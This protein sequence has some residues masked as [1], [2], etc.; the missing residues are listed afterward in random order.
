MA[1][2]SRVTS[3]FAAAGRTLEEAFFSQQDKALVQKLSDLRKL[4]ESKEALA[5]VSG[6]REDAVLEKL[7]SLGIKP[8]IVAALTVVPLVE[9]AWADGRVDEKERDA[10]LYAASSHGIHGDSVQGALIE[11]WLEHKPEPALLEAWR[12]Y[13]QGLCAKLSPE[14][15]QHFKTEFLHGTRAIAESA[16]GL[17]GLGRAVSPAEKRVLEQLELSF[18]GS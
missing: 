7:V 15:R 4:A 13:I 14:Q 1:S 2:E 16:R 11:R 12:H 5:S 6:I 17:L 9:V 10:V 18:S 8:E 3:T